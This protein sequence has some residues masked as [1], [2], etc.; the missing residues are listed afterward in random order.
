MFLWGKS[1]SNYCVIMVSKQKVQIIFNK[2]QYNQKFK[3]CFIL[4]ISSRNTHLISNN[5]SGL[6]FICVMFITIR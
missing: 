5:I 1:G 6:K 2:I 4:S 3:I